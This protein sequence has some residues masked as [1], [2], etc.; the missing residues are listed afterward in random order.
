MITESW[1]N[2]VNRISGSA[3]INNINDYIKQVNHSD[4]P[5]DI[6]YSNTM[7]IIR[8]ANPTFLEEHST[9]GP[10]LLVGLVSATENFFRDILSKIILLCP[11]AKS[12]A[13]DQVIN[14]GSVVWH[15]GQN[16]G[17]GA[18]EHISFANSDAIAKAFRSFI[19]YE[20]NSKAHLKT[21]LEAF[22]KV[23]ELR[24]GI[25]HSNSIIAGKNALK[26]G[27]QPTGQAMKI[28]IGY[29][30]LQECA[31]VCTTVVTTFNAECFTELVRRWAVEWRRY[32]V[33]EDSHR[34]ELFKKIWNCFYSKFDS[35]NNLIRD[36]L[37]LIKCR[38]IVRRH[39][40]IE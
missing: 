10:L 2:S 7:D 17:R 32:G 28:S 24:H 18:F 19:K 30:E 33:I 36:K 25:V 38:N 26:L 9:M 34:N 31:S 12:C 6:F 3:T 16:V 5:I 20:I 1:E 4:S 11:I 39:F 22:D 27:L 35:Q 40:N 21:V 13:S 29:N 14:L 37:T 8:V 15:N 23:C